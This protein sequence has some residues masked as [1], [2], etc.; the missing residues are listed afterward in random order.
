MPQCLRHGQRERGSRPARSRS[1][2]PCALRSRRRCRL[3]RARCRS[4]P[5][6]NLD[7]NK[8]RHGLSAQ[9]TLPRL[10]TPG[11]Q[12][13][14]SHPVPA[15]DAAHRLAS[16]Q[17]LFNQANL[18][19]VTPSSPTF[20]AQDLDLHSPH[21][22]KARLKATSSRR[23]PNYTRRPPPEEYDRT[24][25]P[26]YSNTETQVAAAVALAERVTPA[27]APPSPD[28]KNRDGSSRLQTLVV[29]NTEKPASASAND[30]DLL[31]V[32]LMA[33][34]DIKSVFDL[35]GRASRTTTKRSLSLAD[36]D[37]GFSVLPAT[38]VPGDW[39]RPCSSC[40]ATGERLQPSP[41]R[42]A[43]WRPPPVPQYLNR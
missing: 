1:F 43:Q 36:A 22:L 5:R 24:V 11:E 15:R 35:T 30:K 42:R 38:S 17:R 32:V 39:T 8:R 10:P 9:S 18:L 21:D 29:G 7:R 40:P 31:V 41:A 28:T 2:R 4:R 20:S 34:P 16:L 13:A 37:P 3:W 6:S 33:R 14:L 19:V 25:G 23:L 27:T 12:Q 26:T